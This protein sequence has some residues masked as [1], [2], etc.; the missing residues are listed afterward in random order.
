MPSNFSLATVLPPE[1]KNFDFSH[2]AEEVIK[3]YSLPKYRKRTLETFEILCK[4]KDKDKYKYK[5]TYKYKNMYMYRDTETQR[6]RETE[7]QIQKLSFE[8]CTLDAFFQSSG[9][10]ES[11]SLRYIR[12]P[13]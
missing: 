3:L 10:S 2:G 4:Y 5:H 9:V 8:D 11:T 7:R 12:S 1:P 13:R 6:D